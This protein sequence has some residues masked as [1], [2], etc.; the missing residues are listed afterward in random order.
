ML[1]HLSVQFRSR[2]RRLHAAA[3]LAII[4]SV[5]SVLASHPVLAAIPSPQ[6]RIAPKPSDGGWPREYQ[7]GSLAF[8]VYQP[9][10]ESW[11]QTTLVARSAVAVESIGASGPEYGTIR[12][13]AQTL[14][15]KE[16]GMVILTPIQIADGGFP[17]AGDQ[18]EAYLAALKSQFIT[19]TVRIALGR[20]ETSLAIAQASQQV[21]GQEVANTP[22]HIFYSDQPALL[23]LVD[24]KPVLRPFGSMMRVVNTR[25]LILLD[26]NSGTY[27]LRA[28]GGWFRADQITGPWTPDATPPVSLALALGDAQKQPGIDLLDPVAGAAA[29][30]SPT[31]LLSTEPAELIQTSGRADFLPIPGTDLLYASNTESQL[32]LSLSDQKNYFLVSGR[33]FRTSSLAAGPWEY[34]DQSKLPKDFAKIPEAHPAGG[35]LVSVAGTPQAAEAVISNSIPQTA[36]VQRQGT[37]LTVVYDGTPVFEPIAGTPLACA[38]NTVTPVIQ[39]SPTAYYAVDGAVWFTAASP[40]GPWSVATE[41][42]TVVY[43]IPVRHRLH[44]VTYVRIYRTTTD[45]VIVGYTPGYFGTL[46]A[47]SGC[48][49]YGSG[50]TYDSYCGDFWVP[51]PVTYGWG[52]DFSCGYNTGF[53]FG[54]TAG[55]DLGTWWGPSWGGF[56]WK[57]VEPG[58]FNHAS[59]NHYNAYHQWDTHLVA[60]REP[61]VR[62]QTTIRPPTVLPHEDLVAGQDGNVYRR[63]ENGA[64]ERRDAG[65]WA[66]LGTDNQD[67]QSGNAINRELQVRGQ[68]EER[69]RI[70]PAP[71]QPT[72]SGGFHGGTGGGFSTPAPSGGRKR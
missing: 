52:A 16:S 39:V 13:T 8:T 48:V 14:V 24:G 46:V 29:I 44:F 19:G 21:K 53:A 54:F 47:P 12:F 6:T 35:A 59:F 25:A 38:T 66:P 30:G 58:S 61:V 64:V 49:V 11:D 72:P 40:Q 36:Q 37:V 23:V 60:P 27:H 43:T 65:Q 33:W 67:V 42:P 71:E 57:S 22:P 15:D 26:Q 34:V 56:G 2:S 70:S 5:A 41:V 69:S 1:N 45:S 55:W 50:Y 10:V 9:Q 62:A 28:L 18:S 63:T 17:S 51:A 20:L 68:G 32:F 31:I 3:C 7:A 4:L